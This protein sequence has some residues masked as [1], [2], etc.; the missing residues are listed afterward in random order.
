MDINDRKPYHVEIIDDDIWICKLMSKYLDSWDLNPKHFT[1]PVD[2][3]AYAVNNQPALIM[4]DL[5]MPGINGYSIVQLI[6]KIETTKDIP[7]IIVSGQL[8][9]TELIEG[10]LRQGAN[11]YLEKPFSQRTLY[12]KIKNNISSF[13]LRKYIDINRLSDR[14]I[15]PAPE[16]KH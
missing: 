11:S 13:A 7:I 12:E 6:R 10:I 1:N 5:L 15:T 9:H 8:Q 2:G 16:T 4:L 3:I 14:V